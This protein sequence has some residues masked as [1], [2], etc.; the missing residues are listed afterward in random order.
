MHKYAG[1][2]CLSECI[3]DMSV[4]IVYVIVKCL[5]IL[6]IFWNAKTHVNWLT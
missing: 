2:L 5:I 1:F 4:I 6:K 3:N